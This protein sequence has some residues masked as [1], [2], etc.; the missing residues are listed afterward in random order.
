MKKKILFIDSTED[1]LVQMLQDTGFNCLMKPNTSETKLR[2]LVKEVTGIIIRSRISLNK[3]FLKLAK[4]LKFI[5]RVG[6][7]MENIDLDY[8]KKHNIECINSPEGNRD[9]VGEHAIGMLLC[10]FNKLIVAHNEVSEGEWNR[11]RNRGM[12]IKGKT[13]GIIG[14]GNMGS[15]FASKLIGFGAKI[16]AYDKYKN[17]F[18]NENVEEV[19][20]QSIFDRSEI[21]SLHIP[22]TEETD[23]MVNREFIEQ[24]KNNFTLINTSRGKIVKTSDLVRELK[25][26]KISG[27]CLDVLEYESSSFEILDACDNKNFNYLKKSSNVVLSPHIAGW[28]VESKEKLALIL[29]GKII[30]YSLEKKIIP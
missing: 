30:R 4:E 7:G 26:G 11:E 17:G 21:L 25:S 29:G 10:L 1:I 6:A 2:E 15:S 27:A 5:G 24:F 28:T 13:I 20:L 18:G 12:E 8:A 16:I 23:L 9:A 3:D 14:Y 22:L 19:D